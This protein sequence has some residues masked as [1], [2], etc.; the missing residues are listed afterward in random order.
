ML[1]LSNRLGLLRH[2]GLGYPGSFLP[3]FDPSHVA[4]KS[5]RYSGIA[6]GAAIVNLLNGQA[7]GFNGTVTANMTSIGPTVIGSG[8]NGYNKVSNTYSETPSSSTFAGIFVIKVSETTHVLFANGTPN[9]EQY[10]DI[11][12]LV[13]EMG[14]HSTSTLSGLPA[15]SMNVP[16]FFACSANITTMNFVVRNLITGEIYSTQITSAFTFGA[17]QATWVIGGDTSGTQ[18]GVQTATTMYS[19]AY[20]NLPQLLAW[21]DD[22]WS[23]WYPSPQP[24][25]FAM[26]SAPSGS[27]AYFFP[28]VN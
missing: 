10:A 1:N 18:G 6:I 4:S 9:G 21:A 11:A 5:I 19:V 13:L 3:G 8:P 12:S 7:S 16:Y 25:D 20:M 2:R 26:A 23:F 17:N 27:I 24:F 15:L 22:P 28:W 14:T